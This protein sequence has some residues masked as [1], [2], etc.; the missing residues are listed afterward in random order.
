MTSGRD[1]D[2]AIEAMGVPATF[3]LFEDIVAPG[4]TIAKVGVHGV[5]ADLHLERLWS[6]NI[7]I[8]TRLVDNRYTRS[9]WRTH[10]HPGLT[11]SRRSA[12]S[13]PF[14]TRRRATRPPFSVPRRNVRRLARP[15]NR[16]SSAR[17]QRR[18]PPANGAGV[19]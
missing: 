4:G 12:G 14:L 1:V 19:V 13:S 18:T 15:P 17:A 3:V 11:G 2:T 6:Q 16:R 10:L 7:T 9:H 5:K 8:T